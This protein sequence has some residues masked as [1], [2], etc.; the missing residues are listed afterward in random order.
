MNPMRTIRIEKVTLNFGAGKEHARLEKG[1]KLLK[2]VTGIEPVKTV[3]MK[4]IPTWGLRP[5]LPIGCKITIR[6]NAAL[7]MFQRLLVAHDHKLHETQ[8]DQQGNIAF[9]IPE[10]IDVPGMKYDPELGILGFEVCIT[11]ARPG[12]RIKNR[13]I[14]ARKIPQRHRISKEEAQRFMS[15]VYKVHITKQGEEV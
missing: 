3:T 7:D 12:F 9:G 5:G 1:M 13:R 14:R 2:K 10:Y 11:L 4:R 8:F 6:K 15:E